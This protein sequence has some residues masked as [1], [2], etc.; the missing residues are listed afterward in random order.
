MRTLRDEA[1]KEPTWGTG[2]IVILLVVLIAAVALNFGSAVMDFAIMARRQVHHLVFELP[3]RELYRYGPHIIGWE[4]MELAEVCSRITYHG[5]RDFWSRNMEECEL[6]YAGKEEAFLRVT[7]PL[8]YV[9]FLV[10]C[11]LAIRH[12]VTAYAETKR[13]RTDRVV[14]ETYHAFQTLVRLANRQTTSKRK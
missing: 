7:R 13:D 11:F 6:I 10:T 9:V 3:F 1:K 5:N 14:L 8:S 2:E 4:G 12:L